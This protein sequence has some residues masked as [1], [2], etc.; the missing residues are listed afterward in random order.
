[1]G[2]SSQYFYEAFL[3]THHLYLINSFFPSAPLFWAANGGTSTIDFIGGLVDLVD[4]T[5]TSGVWESSGRRLQLAHAARPID[6]WPVHAVLY[7]PSHQFVADKMLRVPQWDFNKLVGEVKF[8]SNRDELVDDLTVALEGAQDKFD[9]AEQ[10]AYANQYYSILYDSLRRINLQYLRR[11][12][13]SFSKKVSPIEH[14]LYNCITANHTRSYTTYLA[15]RVSRLIAKF[16]GGTLTALWPILILSTF[17]D[18]VDLSKPWLLQ[19][20]PAVHEKQKRISTYVCSIVRIFYERFLQRQSSNAW[21][22]YQKS[23]LDETA[24]AWRTLDFFNGWRLAYKLAGKSLGPTKRRLHTPAPYC[25]SPAEWQS[26][27]SV[28]GSQGGALSTVFC[29]EEKEFARAAAERLGAFGISLSKN[30][31]HREL[32]HMQ[33]KIDIIEVVANFQ[34]VAKMTRLPR[35]IHRK[36]I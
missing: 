10:L 3:Q 30:H 8:G 7:L 24:E 34:G 22:A 15:P 19:F 36:K 29:H 33:Q 25:L 16:V 26:K 17:S 28:E 23:L 6:H 18:V 27:V 21:R 1:M 11:P 32:R 20:S 31:A 12:G 9:D 4:A 35:C 14:E 5:R 13:E 2:K